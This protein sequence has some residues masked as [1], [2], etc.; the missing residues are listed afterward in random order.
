MWEFNV[1]MVF[2]SFYFS[3]GVDCHPHQQCVMVALS[4]QPPNGQFATL[5]PCHICHVI[6]VPH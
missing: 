6:I 4:L 1:P 5:G 3:S 2:E